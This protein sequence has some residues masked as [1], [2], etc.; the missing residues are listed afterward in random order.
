MGITAE[1]LFAGGEL[2]VDLLIP[3]VAVKAA[4]AIDELEIVRRSRA[5]ERARQ[6]RLVPDAQRQ[7][8]GRDRI[9]QALGNDVARQ[10]VADER[11]SDL[12]GAVR[13]VNWQ[14]S[15]C[16]VFEGEIAVQH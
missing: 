12:A 3:A 7:E 9:N 14:S 15:S 4:A 8:L 13:I 11:R 10:R 16:R 1:D 5:A 6:V 2:M